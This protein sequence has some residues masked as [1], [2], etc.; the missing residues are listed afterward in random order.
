MATLDE[1]E[2]TV[3]ER[4]GDAI[5]EATRFRDAL[6]LRIRR[7]AIREVCLFLRDTPEMRFNWL[8]SV[9]AVDYLNMGRKPRFDVVYHVLSLDHNHRLC[10]KTF[11]PEEDNHVASVV[12]VWPGA[13]WHERETFDLFGI[14]FDDH[15][16]LRRILLADDWEGYPLRKDFPV[17][18]TP[19]FYFK[20][21]TDA[22]AGEPPGLVPRIRVQ[23]SDI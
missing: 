10:L 21:D 3:R 7:E 20:R 13:N 8:S 4:F 16:D 12:E 5:V 11:V 2:R 9:T 14:V 1:I 17:G 15:P 19:S 6:T 23:D 18:G 22:H